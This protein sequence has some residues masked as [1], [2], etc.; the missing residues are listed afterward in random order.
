ML[1]RVAENV[2][3]LSRYLE[4][5]EN[6]ARLIRVYSRSLMD[7]PGVQ[8][9]EGWMPLISITGLDIEYLKYFDHANEADVSFFLLS[10]SRNPGSL[11]NA[12]SAIKNN[13]RSSRDIFP[14]KMYEKISRLVRFIRSGVEQGINT[15]NRDTILDS[16]ERQ[17]LEISGA[18]YSSLRHDDAYRFMRMATYIERADM[19]SRVLDV[20]TSILIT[21]NQ[22]DNLAPFENRHWA[23]ALNSVSAMQVYR[24]HVRQPVNAE[25]CLNFLLNDEPVSYT[26]L[27][28]PTT[29]YV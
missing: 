24:R 23:G 19:I 16:I 1:A 26:H 5:I 27:T 7:L 25:G 29:P 3:W 13:L 21:D 10:D 17:V 12:A 2:Y 14:K 18:V 9:H 28:L 4:R 6:T 15:T 22:P 20:P 8:E 11:V